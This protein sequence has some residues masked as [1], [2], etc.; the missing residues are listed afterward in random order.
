MTDKYVS[1]E[2][3]STEYGRLQMDH[4]YRDR[5]DDKYGDCKFFQQINVSDFL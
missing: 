2:D 4:E 5:V 1:E 3:F